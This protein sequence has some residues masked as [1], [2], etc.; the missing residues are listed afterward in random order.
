MD[1]IVGTER[2][3][4]ECRRRRGHVPAGIAQRYEVIG[5][6]RIGRVHLSPVGDEDSD[7]PDLYIVLPEVGEK[8]LRRTAFLRRFRF[9]H[10]ADRSISNT[11]WCGESI[12]GLPKISRLG[13][14]GDLAF[15][16]V[17]SPSMLDARPTLVL[18]MC[19]GIGGGFDFRR[20]RGRRSRR[21]Q[22]T[23]QMSR[24]GARAQACRAQ[25]YGTP[26]ALP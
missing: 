6:A 15:N 17:A 4:H 11:P 26:I 24:R 13:T 23:R 9:G 14:Y 25:Q 16:R 7:R 12:S 22:R 19:N 1:P 3:A 10:V 5:D 20:R 18:V 21:L 8:G 2:R